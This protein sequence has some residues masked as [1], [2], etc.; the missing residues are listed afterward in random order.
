MEILQFLHP[1]DSIEEFFYLL[2]ELGS[3]ADGNLRAPFMAL[4]PYRVVVDDVGAIF[5]RRRRQNHVGIVLLIQSLAKH[6]HVK[7]TQK[8]DLRNG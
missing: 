2:W 8:A 1:E 4:L 6:L 7:R 5:D 3:I